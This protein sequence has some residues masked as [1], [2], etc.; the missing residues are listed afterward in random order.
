VAVA[1]TICAVAW[2]GF[3]VDVGFLSH[4]SALLVA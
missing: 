4:T 2:M 3:R 1:G